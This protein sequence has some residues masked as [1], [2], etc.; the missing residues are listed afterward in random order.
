MHLQQYLD[1]IQPL[2]I[3]TKKRSDLEPTVYL[4]DRLCKASPRV[5]TTLQSLQVHYCVLSHYLTLLGLVPRLRSFH[6]LVTATESNARPHWVAHR[7][8]KLASHLRNGK[9]PNTKES[10]GYLCVIPRILTHC[11]KIYDSK[12]KTYPNA[13]PLPIPYSLL[14]SKAPF[15]VFGDCFIRRP[16]DFGRL[17]GRI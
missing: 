3:E 16:W 12:R 2:L 11:V 9:P 14:G 4:T 6:A 10:H 17:P 7:L 1:L 8:T 15:P 5:K 13:T